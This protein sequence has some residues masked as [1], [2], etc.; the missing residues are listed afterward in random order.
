MRHQ[1]NFLVEFIGEQV[2]VLAKMARIDGLEDLAF[3]LQVARAE[4]DRAQKKWHDDPGN[5]HPSP[6]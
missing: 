6:N 4:A 1:G 3:I 5:R 2:E